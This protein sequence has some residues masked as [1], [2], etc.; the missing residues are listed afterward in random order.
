MN[1]NK[2]S[3]ANAKRVRVADQ[4]AVARLTVV[5]G[6]HRDLVARLPTEVLG[7]HDARRPS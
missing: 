6:A 3:L 7:F 5:P 2:M 1:T 4:A